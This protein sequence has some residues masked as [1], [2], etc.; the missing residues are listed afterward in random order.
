MTTGRPAGYS[1]ISNYSRVEILHLVQEQPRRTVAE[2]VDATDLHPNT[3][4][5]H[6]QR[7]I[8]DGYVVSASEHRTTRGRPRVLYSATDGINSHSPVQHRRVRAA[9]E[10]GD[11]MRRVLPGS[12]P[13]L[14]TAALHQI[15]ALVED[16][17]DA[18]FDPLV[19]ERELT[20]ELT[21]CAQASAQADHREVLCSVHLGI[22]QSVLSSAD[23]PLSVDGMRSS[24]D[25]RECIVQ[26]LHSAQRV[27]QQA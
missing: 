13:D 20:V 3:V 19:D 1:A 21:P 22:M 17:V 9:A 24:C 2:L 8:D 7:L 4:R 6:L 5:E 10:R 26:L 15:D 25:P 11:L 27:P 12:T 23:G 14:D 16:L 18:G